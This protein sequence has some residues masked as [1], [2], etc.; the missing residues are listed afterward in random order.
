MHAQQQ[1]ACNEKVGHE[2]GA[3]CLKVT[4][5]VRSTE[6]NGTRLVQVEMHLILYSCF[7]TGDNRTVCGSVEELPQVYFMM[8]HLLFVLSTI[9]GNVKE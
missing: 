4:T 8:S 9:C 6:L 5:W 3:L 1:Q 7:Q 2:V